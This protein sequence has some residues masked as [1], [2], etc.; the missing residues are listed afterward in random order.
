M[1]KFIF[2]RFF[3]IFIYITIF[4][5]TCF[6]SMFFIYKYIHII[7]MYKCICSSCCTNILLT[8]YFKF[9]SKF[10]SS[11]QTVGEISYA[12]LYY[13]SVQ[14][15]VKI[16][17]VKIIDTVFFL[18]SSLKYFLC[19][20]K[21]IHRLRFKLFEMLKKKVY[22]KSLGIFWAKLDF[23]VVFLVKFSRFQ[24]NLSNSKQQLQFKLFHVDYRFQ[25]TI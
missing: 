4:I 23:W 18:I 9:Y 1:N 10:S 17:T 7:C 6:I 25:I 22:K 15:N 14:I 19:T 20:S 13:C 16:N 2:K 12:S 3:Y 21:K 11:S 8:L 5:F 24:Q